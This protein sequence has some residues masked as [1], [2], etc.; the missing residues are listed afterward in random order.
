MAHL[1]T[2]RTFGLIAALMSSVAGAACTGTVGPPGQPAGTPPPSAPGVTGGG[3]GLAHDGVGSMPLRRLSR[4]EYDRTLRDLLGEVSRPG[5]ALPD[6]T[7]G[8][9]F[10]AP[11]VT[12]VAEVNV[13]LDAAAGVADAAIARG[14]KL[15]G[16]DPASGDACFAQWLPAF[17]RRAYRRPVAADELSALQ[18]LFA[19]ARGELKLTPAQAGSFVLQAMLNSPWFLYHWELG[20]VPARMTSSAGMQAVALTGYERAS[21]LSYF[22][23]GSMPDD[24]LFSTAESG[25]LDSAAGVMTQARRLLADGKAQDALV[26]FHRQWLAL[27]D[28]PSDAGDAFPKAAADETAAFVAYVFGEGGGKLDTLLTSHTVFAN[29]ALAPAYGLKDVTGTPLV[30]RELDPAQRFGILT[31]ANFLVTH[32]AGADSHP[33]KR[34]VQIV[35]KLL[36]QELPPPPAM[37]APVTAAAANLSTRERY[38]AH[39]QNACATACHGLIDP[40]GFSLEH[41]DGVGRWRDSDGGKPVD[42]SGTLKLPTGT[43]MSFRDFGDL[44]KTLAAS[45]DVHRCVTSQWASFALGRPTSD[46]EGGSLAATLQAFTAGG[47]DLR[48]L[49]VAFTTTR[50]FLNRKPAAGEVLR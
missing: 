35:K 16:C 17:A 30:R 29:Q 47:F 28:P 26:T 24:A 49:M 27:P 44:S 19:R 41:Y 42:A 7:N 37:V 48:E 43:M 40:P 39:E 38:A 31:Q 12:G 4:D 32:G 46:E 3:G 18:A 33:V 6:D 14:A 20:P 34:G 13:L 22:L 23:W 10:A 36:C 11:G 15:F 1:A 5:R 45:D 8:T 50:T 21:R 2:L 9:T 25:G